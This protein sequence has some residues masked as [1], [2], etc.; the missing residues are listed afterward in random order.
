VCRGLVAGEERVLE[1]ED[2][3]DVLVTVTVRDQLSVIG[4]RRLYKFIFVL[5]K[6]FY[7]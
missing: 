3:R 2:R 5:C 1:A 6:N 7:F 4:E